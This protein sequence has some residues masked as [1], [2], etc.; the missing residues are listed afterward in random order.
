MISDKEICQRIAELE[1]LTV[2][3]DKEAASREYYSTLCVIIPQGPNGTYSYVY[4]PLTDK[5]LAFELLEKYDI[6]IDSYTEEGVKTYYG[7]VETKEG[8]VF[9]L[10]DCT[11]L[12]RFICLAVLAQEDNK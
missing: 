10:E 7:W 8:K 11:D 4:N 12:R 3:T 2:A 5:V 6:A 9:Q 1:G